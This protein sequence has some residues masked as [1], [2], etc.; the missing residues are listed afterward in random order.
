MDTTKYFKLSNPQRRIWYTE[1]VNENKDMSNIAY[2]VELKGEYDLDKL[3]RAIR[4]VVEANSSLRLRFKY[5]DEDRSDM[6]QYIPEYE[7]IDVVRIEAAGEDEL[8]REIETLH[9]RRFDVPG[10]DLCAFAVYSIEGKRFG[11]FQKA[12]HLVADG[13]SANNVAREVIETYRNMDAPDFEPVKKEYAYT[14]FLEDEKEYIAGEKYKKSKAYWAQ[15]FQDFQGEDITFKSNKSQ[16]N[17]FEVNRGSFKLPRELAQCFGEYN[18][19]NRISNFALFMA[20][21]GIYFN[22]FY[23]HDDMV[24]GMPVHNRNK[25]YFRDMVG[26]FVST[27]PFRMKF[28]DDWTFDDLIAYVKKGL[29]DGLKNQAYPF[30]HLVKDLKEMNIA[31]D[32]LLNVQLIELPGGMDDVIESRYFFSTQYNISTLSLYLNQQTKKE[33]DVLEVAIDYHGDVFDEQEIAYLFKRLLVI[34]EQGVKSP[35]KKLSELSLLDEPE[36]RELTEELN[37]TGADFPGDQTI[38]EIFARRVAKNPGKIALEYDGETVTYDQLNIL[39]DKIAV[40]LRTAGVGPDSIVG[41]LC[42]RS[43]EAVV[44]ILGILKAGGAYL[45]IDPAYPEDRKKYII[46]NSGTKI[47]I[48]EKVLEQQE[49]EVLQGIPG[50]EVIVA[51]A[52]E[53]TEQTVVLDFQEPGITGKNLAYVIYT[54]GTTGKPKGTLLTHRNALNYV[55]WGERMYVKGEEVR[56]PLFTSLSFDLTVTSVLIPLLTGNGIVIYRDYDQGLLIEKVVR[57]NKANIIKLTPSHLKIVKELKCD[58]SSIRRFIVGGEELKTDTAREIDDYFSGNVDICNEYGPTEAT[59]GCMIHVYDKSVDTGIAVPIGKPADNV[60]IYILDKEKRM[61]PLGVIGEIYI[62]GEG[63]A[64]GYLKNRPLSDERFVDNPFVPGEK[65]Y[66][67]GD[68]GRWNLDK[69]L[70]FYGRCDEQVKIRGFRI[71]PGEI[72][73]RLLEIEEIKDAVVVVTEDKAAQKS[74]CAYMV[75]KDGQEVLDPETGERLDTRAVR[76][77]LGENLPDYM[78]PSFFVELEKIPLTNN[79]KVDKRAL[80]EPRAQ[81]KTG[82]GSDTVPAGEME[83]GIKK[84]WSDVLG[85]E[86]AMGDNF[87]EMGGDSIKAVQIASRMN[88][89]DLSVNVKDI[90]GFQTIEQLVLN[91]DFHKERRTYEQG[92]LEGKKEASPIESWFFE[93]GFKNP[94]YFN[95]SA[96]LEF[97]GD[98]DTAVLVKCFNRLIKHHDGLRLNVEPGVGTFFYNNEHLK[99]DVVIEEFEIADDGGTAWH[100][101]VRELGVRVKSSF[102]IEQSLLIKPAVIRLTSGK[103]LLL[104]TAHHLVIDGV[105]WRLLLEDLFKIYQGISKGE[106]VVLSDKTGSLTDWRGQ[107]EE[108]AGREELNEEIPFWN[109]A[110]ACDFSLSGNKGEGGIGTVADRA[111][112][113]FEFDLEKTEVLVSGSRKTFNSDVEVL[114]VTALSKALGEYTGRDRLVLELENHGRH[115][116][117]VDLA[118]TIGWF[119]AMYPMLVT[120]DKDDLVGRIKSVKEQLRGVPGNGI[121]YGVLKYISG[122]LPAEYRSQVRFNYLGQFDQEVSNEI[123]GYSEI[124][125]GE[126][127]AMGNALSTVIEVNCMLMQGRL[128]FDMFY[129]RKVFDGDNI[130]GSLLK[131]IQS[132]LEEMIKYFSGSEDEV[133]FTSSDFDTVDLDDDDLDA[134]FG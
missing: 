31:T 16:L 25:K 18:K 75:P 2:L 74:L 88:D 12:H 134:L 118:R 41:I 9:R 122:K 58:V 7:E 126:D 35:E 66:K 114:L 20:G 1:L 32:G 123:F 26:M 15:R 76:R 109:E 106:D 37:A 129:S 93:R 45:P 99:K 111:K 92:P 13:I 83:Q 56:F 116:E 130:E 115:L 107:L 69:V 21:L 98:I 43:I 10:R 51:D 119:T 48:L 61:L 94:N 68:L 103:H 110:M 91:V 24:I 53:M 11:F 63:V 8:F 120:L 5:A 132:A 101:K 6:L 125:T 100:E 59:V 29:W 133:H 33:L 65:M 113:G 49:R 70:E 22:R 86:V 117:E 128:V 62:G 97:S 14:D 36:Y 19:K 40:R 79:G 95:Q 38:P 3:S 85:V 78:V 82:A 30:N 55:W 71:E 39:T 60:K 73:K 42:E 127:I 104:I 112:V 46:E 121:G 105:S 81:V 67:S 50:L 4:L 84:I 77:V 54:S 124:L 57:D 108:Y 90:L 47:L 34:L 87:F 80:P 89:M 27:L 28:E 23:N 17:T 96:L 131:R 102:D 72:E 64:R 44:S 52:T